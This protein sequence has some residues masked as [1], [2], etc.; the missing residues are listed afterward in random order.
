MSLR[1]SGGRRLQS[2]VGLSVRP[3]PA[4]V[5]QAVMNILSAELP[6]C[7]WLDLCSGSGVMACEALQRGAARVVAIEHDR[8]H[9][10]VAR[11][12]LEAVAGAL[13][14]P[15]QVH[16][17]AQVQSLVQVHQSEVLRW[18]RAG[19]ASSGEEPFDLI[20]A[21]PPYAAGLYGE[22]AGG[23]RDGDWLRPGGT[24]L[25]ECSSAAVQVPPPGWHC[26]DQRRYGG[27]TVVRLS[28]L[29]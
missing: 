13:G 28:P 25:L 16:G 24:L 18:L 23:V 6:G 21:D 27:T 17:Q 7:R 9:A 26:T 11:A 15:H 22:L 29:I 8:R 2:P 3:T 10:A 4:R 5:R 19:R 1:V 12:N 14:G 20:Y